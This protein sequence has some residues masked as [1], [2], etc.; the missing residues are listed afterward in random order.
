[1]SFNI[2]YMHN[3]TTKCKKNNIYTSSNVNVVAFSNDICSYY[4]SKFSF[5]LNNYNINTTFIH[6]TYIMNH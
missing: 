6:Y 2:V 5:A 1:M 4:G 3:I